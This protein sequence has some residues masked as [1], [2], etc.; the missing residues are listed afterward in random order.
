MSSSPAKSGKVDKT[1]SSRLLTMKFMQ[2]A[3]ASAAAKESQSSDSDQHNTKR[4]R[5]S[6]DNRTSAAQSDLEAISAALAEE[7]KKRREA[8]SQ[9]AAASGETEWT[10]DLPPAAPQS[11][12][13]AVEVDVSLDDEEL[14]GRRSFGGHKRKELEKPVAPVESDLT[15]KYR[16]MVEEGTMTQA[17]M[18]NRMESKKLKHM[19]GISGS[20]GQGIHHGEGKKKKRKSGDY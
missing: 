2:R 18:N 8:M 9:T 15:M 20:G 11:Q 5:K 3:A 10:L 6:L 12:P 17:E 4:Q 13:W 14:G 1:M 19:S 7:E 16:R